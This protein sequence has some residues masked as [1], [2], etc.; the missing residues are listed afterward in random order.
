MHRDIETN[1]RV[2]LLAYR[3]FLEVDRAWDMALREL[4]SWFP[5]AKQVGVS[6]LG[7]PGSPIRRL[8]DQR[9]RALRQL[10]AAYQKLEVAKK[11]M[12]VRRQQTLAQQILFIKDDGY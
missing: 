5:S 1:R 8:H 9:D 7:N 3:R 10:E 6:T 2:L 11:R 12:A 4:N